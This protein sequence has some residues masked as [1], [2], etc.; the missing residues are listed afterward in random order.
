MSRRWRPDASDG[1]MPVQKSVCTTLVGGMDPRSLGAE[2]SWSEDE[3]LAPEPT[4]DA[5]SLLVARTAC[6]SVRIH[7]VQ[8]EMSVSTDCR[9]FLTFVSLVVVTARET[10]RDALPIL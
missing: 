1:R 6:P 2:A 7:P 10:R 9:S 5:R 8:V 3:L 4:F